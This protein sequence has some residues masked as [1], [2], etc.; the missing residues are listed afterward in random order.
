MKVTV[1]QNARPE[2]LEEKINELGGIDL[3]S[4]RGGEL[5]L[6]FDEDVEP[7]KHQGAIGRILDD[8]EE[9]ELISSFRS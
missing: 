4:S 2:E 7:W 5:V 1:F 9:E 8:L 6:E 3:V